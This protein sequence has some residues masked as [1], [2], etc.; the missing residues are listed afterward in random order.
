M[1]ILSRLPA[2]ILLLGVLLLG[3][4]AATPA[5]PAD[6]VDTAGLRAGITAARLTDHL[7]AL[8]R[9]ARAN[10]G[11]RAVG[12]PGYQASVDYVRERLNASGYQVTLQPFQVDFADG[13]VHLRGPER[14]DE[15]FPLEFLLV[16]L[17]RQGDIDSQH[18]R[19]IDLSLSPG[20]P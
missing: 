15:P 9:I 20:A 13:L 16:R 17:H 19:Q 10:G 12:T 18:Q 11:N 1:S 14:L 6:V 2:W 3:L 4:T 7:A 5:V 8:D